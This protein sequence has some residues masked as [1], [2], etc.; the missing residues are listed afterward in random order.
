MAQSIS[1]EELQLKKR[2][3]RR[4]VGAIALMLL[5]VVFL[6]MVL[7]KE[8]KPVGQD[9]TIRIPSQEATPFR[10]QTPAP[11]AAPQVNQVAPK[12]NQTVPEVPKQSA[13]AAQKVAEKPVATA[14]DVKPAEAPQQAS[15]PKSVVPA[16]NAKPA[17]S[18][19]DAKQVQH[20]PTGKLQGY[21]IQ[22]GAFANMNNAKQRQARLNALGVRFYTEK[23]KTPGGEKLRIRAG[24]YATREEAE[25][26]MNRLKAQGIKD[27]VIAEKN[28]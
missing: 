19:P 11:I 12:V 24:P 7:D 15:Q 26:V 3:R 8:P 10:P 27:G 18:D 25:K 6:P 23:I 21:E 4:L 14:E 2:A 22:L 17:K 9:I 16:E 1:D 5:A 13:G 28:S 20:A